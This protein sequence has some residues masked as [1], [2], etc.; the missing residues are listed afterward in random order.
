MSGAMETKKLS[1]SQGCVINKGSHP[2]TTTP[3]GRHTEFPSGY[4]GAAQMDSGQ[5]S[6]WTAGLQ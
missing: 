3:V 2:P 1:R 5:L 4:Q 6:H